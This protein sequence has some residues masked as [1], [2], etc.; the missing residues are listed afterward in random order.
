MTLRKRRKTK[1]NYNFV[2]WVLMVKTKD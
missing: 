1:A 2:L